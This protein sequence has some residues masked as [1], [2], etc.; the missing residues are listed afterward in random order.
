MNML[1]KCSQILVDG[2]FKSC[3][4]SYYQIIHIAGF[5]PDINSIIP[6]F[7]I[8]LSG[9]NLY[10]YNCVF[11]DVKKILVDNGIN[12][13]KIPN[14]IITDF[15]KGLLKSIKTNFP[16]SII[17]G[18]YFHFVKLLWS[19]AKQFGLCKKKNLKFSKILIFLLK[20]I[21]FLPLDEKNLV[22]DKID[23]FFSNN[24]DKYWKMLAYYKKNW[25]NNN[26][27]NF[28]EL[29]QEEYINRTNSFHARLNDKLQCYH[30]KISYLITKYKEYLVDIYEKIKT[31]LVNVNNNKYEKFSIIKDIIDFITKYNDKYKSELN[32]NILI[33]SNGEEMVAINKICDYVLEF[34]FDIY[35][36]EYI[37]NENN[38]INEDE[39]I[40]SVQNNQNIN[41]NLSQNNNNL[42]CINIEKSGEDE[43]DSES[44]DDDE[45]VVGF[46]EF[47]PKIIK[48][49]KKRRNYLDAFGED[50]ELKKFHGLLTINSK[51]SK[52]IKNN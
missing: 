20:I 39:N 21:P 41:I 49:K 48:N 31:S 44:N 4:N 43:N 19:K 9:K 45:D 50:N 1:T 34:F 46:D 47:Y 10:L 7:M 52:S 15:E 2:T 26:Y 30:P 6:I 24:K 33:Q 23:T 5:F 12:I 16:K 32:I 13:N 3:P 38:Y 25:L 51:S 36:N 11:E 8:P 28:S 35:E 27:I 14:R 40:N 42:N 17:D 18:C 29:S 22:F 37:V